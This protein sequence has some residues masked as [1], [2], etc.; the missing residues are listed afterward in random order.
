MLKKIF[1]LITFLGL[2]HCSSEKTKKNNSL[3]VAVLLFSQ[4]QKSS[5]TTTPSFSVPSDT[6]DTVTS[7]ANHTGLDFRD[8]A[9]AVNGVRGA[10]ISSGGVDVFSLTATG[11]TA[12]IVLEWSGRRILNGSGIDF[13]VFEN[14]FQYSANASTV[15]MEAIIVEVSQDNISYCG[16]SPSYNF[17]PKTTY[18][19]TPSFWLRF[20]GI[21]PTLYNLETNNF[22]GND[23]YD[24][25]K[26]GGDGFDLEN[27]SAANDFGIGC[28]V[29]LRDKIKSEGFVYLRLTSATARTNPDTGS[30]YLQD[31]GAFGGGPDIDGVLARYRAVR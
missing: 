24:L 18:S 28:S 30:N 10:G 9:K 27:L 1:I 3:M 6:A 4:T 19:T 12:S 23:L 25:T 20:A 14:A 17:S 7:A 31:V 5:S 2:I 13:T 11:N 16:F 26:T 22:I 29:T 21:T 15:F 8:K